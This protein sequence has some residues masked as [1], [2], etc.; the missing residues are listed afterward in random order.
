MDEPKT[1][2]ALKA[3]W[4]ER[5]WSAD[6]S[7]SGLEQKSLGADSAPWEESRG[8]HGEESLQAYWRRNPATGRERS[9]E[10]MEESGELI[11]APDNTLWHLAHV[12]LIWKNQQEAKLGWDATRKNHLTNILHERLSSAD[13]SYIDAN[14]PENSRDG[15]AQLS[16]MVLSEYFSFKKYELVSDHHPSVRLVCFQTWFEKILA[17]ELDF[18]EEADFS[19][20]FFANSVNFSKSKIQGN[21]IFNSAIFGGRAVF[22]ETEFE[23]NVMFPGVFFFKGLSFSKARIRGDANFFDAEVMANSSF[24][25]A[26]FFGVARFER[27]K[28]RDLA[29]FRRSHF[30][31]QANFFRA[32][33]SAGNSFFGSRFDQRANF[34]YSS[35][36]EVARFA[37]SSFGGRTSFRGA[38]F[39]RG[40]L[41]EE[42]NDWGDKPSEWGR[43][44]FDTKASGLMSFERSTIP[45]FGIFHG[46]HLERG[47]LL[48]LDDPGAATMKAAFAKQLSE[49]LDERRRTSSD[50]KNDL[51]DQFNRL[52]A[53][54]V[55]GC[56]FLKNYFEAIADRDLAQRFFRFELEARMKSGEI[57]KMER[58]VFGGYRIFSD[59]GASIGRPLKW[60]A[61]SVFVFW[62]FYWFIAATWL[63]PS[64]SQIRPSNEPYSI[65][66][67][68]EVKDHFLRGDFSAIN[69]A[70][71]L[72]ALSFSAHRTFP[73]GAW[74]VKAEDKDNNMRKILL[75]DGEGG[76][77]FTVRALAT[78][79]S[80]FSLA[81]IFLSGL[82]IRRR[83]KMD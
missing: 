56:R 30:H 2:E 3:G 9:D 83:F 20:A 41:F 23:K 19:N 62:F 47:S 31:G 58:W 1:L 25:D 27:T 33:I 38:L 44:F 68:F 7:W 63:N 67:V 55:G 60:L 42:I 40:A 12:P 81:M 77:H 46:L 21:V 73:I 16:G 76:A 49:I 10:E 52:S 4:W 70:P 66:N 13:A 26:D 35:F 72:G 37:S 24:D 71:I 39:T 50:Q 82:A 11:R 17:V 14:N 29:I 15:R 78:I 74:D 80:I 57:E 32:E 22:F 48:S 79:Q 65:Q 34:D 8:L 64:L 75:G 6:Y 5:W 59:Y 28:F 36:N 61:S 45:P 53:D 69:L 51:G 54:L 18:R 43:A